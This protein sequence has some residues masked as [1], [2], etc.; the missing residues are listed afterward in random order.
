MRLTE[1]LAAALPIAILLG[2]GI[3]NL[4]ATGAPRSDSTELLQN[5]SF[6]LNGS[7]SLDGWQPGNPA[8]AT[9]ITPGGPGGGDWSLRLQADWAPTLGFVV[10]NIEG[11]QSGDVVELRVDV[12][13]AGTDG[14]GSIGLRVGP[15]PWTGAGKSAWT[16]SSEWTTLTVVD[17]LQF[18][19]GDSLWVQLSS[20]NT[21]I[22]PR[23]GLFDNASLTRV[24]FV[25]V[26]PT[27]WGRLKALY[28]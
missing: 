14:G 10:Q 26:E 15:D 1:R 25:A 23:V 16:A 12:K 8:L 22:V 24:G 13:A 9:L 5:G 3:M 17:T 27:T 21:E 7:P 18:G 19:E 28:H 2:I 6:E 20:F 4:P 11:L